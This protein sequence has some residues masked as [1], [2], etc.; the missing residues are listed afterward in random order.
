MNPNGNAIA[1][2]AQPRPSR[3]FFLEPIRERFSIVGARRYGST[4][5][6]FP[7]SDIS[8]FQGEDAVRRI[9]SRLVELA[10][11]ESR[12]WIALTGRTASLAMLCLTLAWKCGRVR[13]LV[14][15]AESSRYVSRKIERD[16]IERNQ[17]PTA[18]E[19]R[20]AEA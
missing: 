1:G 20:S 7:D 14:F 16:A 17:E 4:V 10:F 2:A 6:L 9:R 13:L 15:D 3:V 12:D 5:Y 19:R 18:Q 8:A 11:D